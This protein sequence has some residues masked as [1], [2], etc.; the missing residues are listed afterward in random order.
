MRQSFS[1]EYNARLFAGRVGFLTYWLPIRD[2]NFTF[3]GGWP[4]KWNAD[5]MKMRFQ[6]FEMSCDWVVPYKCVFY[7]NTSTGHDCYTFESHPVIKSKSPKSV[8]THPFVVSRTAA[9]YPIGAKINFTCDF[10]GP[11]STTLTWQEARCEK[12]NSFATS[13]LMPRVTEI[14]DKLN[15]N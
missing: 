10:H 14:K 11:E 4:K 7:Y 1:E 3:S 12:P 5:K 15:L 2:Y 13:L 8:I 9:E 6:I